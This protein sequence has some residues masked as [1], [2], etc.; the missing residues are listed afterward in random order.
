MNKKTPNIMHL[1]EKLLCSTLDMPEEPIKQV[2]DDYL[3]LLI[4]SAVTNIILLVALIMNFKTPNKTITREQ[5]Q[6]LDVAIERMTE[7]TDF[8]KLNTNE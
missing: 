1:R 4:I 6:K 5:E 7:V 3:S 8:I 2:R